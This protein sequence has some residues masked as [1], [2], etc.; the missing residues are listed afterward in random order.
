MVYARVG[1]SVIVSQSYRCGCGVGGDGPRLADQGE[2]LARRLC[3]SPHVPAVPSIAALDAS[4]TLPGAGAVDALLQAAVGGEE[5][6]WAAIQQVLQ[7]MLRV[8]EGP[9]Q[10]PAAPSSSLADLRA[11]LV[12][13]ASPALRA[14]LLG[15]TEHAPDELAARLEL[16]G[17]S[18]GEDGDAE[19][20]RF[21]RD[22]LFGA[23]PFQQATLTHGLA[24]LA[25]L[26]DGAWDAG[27]DAV[28]ARARLMAWD[29]LIPQTEVRAALAAVR[30]PLTED[31]AALLAA[32]SG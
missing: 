24:L 2:E 15:G 32:I 19:L 4:R 25:V 12:E 5:D 23:R 26:L 29:D 17:L 6:P 21:V 30:H 9:S 14:V 3:L 20:A 18:P 28:S 27:L 7:D 31:A 22:H 10:M 8:S 11:A 1:E 13:V 16:R